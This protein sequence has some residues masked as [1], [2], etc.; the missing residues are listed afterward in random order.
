MLRTYAQIPARAKYFLYDGDLALIDENVPATSI[1]T[2]PVGS[3]ADLTSMATAAEVNATSGF[4]SDVTP[5]T[6][7]LKDM[8]R[9]ITIYDATTH[10]HLAVYRQVQV[11]NGIASEGVGGSAPAWGSNYFVKVWAADGQG[12]AVIRT[13]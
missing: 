8:G 6:N 12:V 5:A 4:D 2:L 13:G 1:F 10:L 7:L 9:Q 3:Y 11:V